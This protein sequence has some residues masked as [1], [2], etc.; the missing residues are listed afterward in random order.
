MTWMWRGCWVYIQQ[1]LLSWPMSSCKLLKR[2]SD[3]IDHIHCSSKCSWKTYCEHCM[4]ISLLQAM[5]GCRSPE[6]TVHCTHVF[7]ATV[8][9]VLPRRPCCQ[10]TDVTVLNTSTVTRKPGQRKHPRAIKTTSIKHWHDCTCMDLGPNW[11]LYSTCTTF[12]R[13]KNYSL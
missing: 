11:N 8:V 5:T 12:L 6:D 13:L 3:L 9:A 4:A 7:L 1:K 10:R 2:V